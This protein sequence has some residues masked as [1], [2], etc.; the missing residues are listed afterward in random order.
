MCGPTSRY[1]PML[2]D[3]YHIL[4]SIISQYLNQKQEHLFRHREETNH[5]PT[6][7]M[8]FAIDS[9]VSPACVSIGPRWKG[10]SGTY[11]RNCSWLKPT[12]VRDDLLILICNSL[13]L[14]LIPPLTISD[15]TLLAAA[16]LGK[17]FSTQKAFIEVQMIIK[18]VDGSINIIRAR[19][20]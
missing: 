14:D 19:V 18:L 1:E 20:M 7:S 4:P 3:S 9:G 11:Q 16:I 8:A 15:K 12:P 2:F 13:F 5:L 17:P 10:A 6:S